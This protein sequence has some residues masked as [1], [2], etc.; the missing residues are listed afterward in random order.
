MLARRDTGISQK[1]FALVATLTALMLLAVIVLGMLSLSTIELRNANLANHRRQAQANARLALTQAIGQLQMAMGPD[2]R[3]SASSAL[4]TAEG[5]QHWT[6]VWDAQA[7]DGKPWVVRD[8]NTGGLKDRRLA[9]DY[10]PG[11]RV[12]RWLVSGSS[13]P[14]E[15]GPTRVKLV[16]AGSVADP[17]TMGV[18]VPAVEIATRGQRGKMAWWTGDLGQRANLATQATK[19]ARVA[20]QAAPEFIGN[21]PPMTANVRNRLVSE[22]SV[23]MLAGD[24]GWAKTH[25]HDF[26]VHSRG[27]LTNTRD[28]GLKQDLRAYFSSDGTL[29]AE[30]DSPGLTDTDRLAGPANE[31]EAEAAGLPW[32]R[33]PFRRAAPR[34]GVLRHW[35]G[36]AAPRAGGPLEA[37]PPETVAVAP[38]DVL[39]NF[40]PVRLD[41]AL[42]SSIQPILV[43]ASQWYSFSWFRKP[44]TDANRRHLRKHLYPKIVLWNPYS[45]AMTTR[46]MM[47]LLQV[48]GRHDFWIDGYFPGAKGKPG[49]PVHSPWLAF[50]GGR[51]RDFV[52]AD[53][54]LFSSSGYNDPHMGSYYYQ[55]APTRFAPGECLVFTP[56]KAGDYRN[57]VKEDGGDTNLA[58]NLLTAG[59]APHP[60]RCITISDLPGQPGF[61][62]VPTGIS[63]ESTAAHFALFGMQ[64]LRNPAEDLRVILKGMGSEKSVDVDGF[65]KLPQIAFISGSLQYGAGTEPVSPWPGSVKI[66]IEETTA[67]PPKLVP[68][69]RTRQGLRLRHGTASPSSR[70]EALF[71]N[72]NPRAAFSLRSPRE[73]F[74]TGE[75]RS[76]LEDNF[77]GFGIY[78]RFLPPMD[79]TATGDFLSEKT[80]ENATATIL[81]DLPDE[82][83]GVISIGSLQHAKLSDLVWLPSRVI[84]NSLADPRIGEENTIPGKLDHM[85]FTQTHLG[86]PSD[87]N[88]DAWASSA[89]AMLRN[90]PADD[91]ELSYDLAYETNHALW[92]RFFVSSEDPLFNPRLETHK[93]PAEA[94]S[95]FTD[96]HQAAFQ[97]TINGPLNVNSLSVDAWAAV[98]AGIR[99]PGAKTLHLTESEIRRL[100]SAVV[101]Q[102]KLRGPFLGMS[103]FVNRRLAPGVTGKFG[104]IEAA[105]Q[106]AGLNSQLT[107]RSPLHDDASTHSA[108][109]QIPAPL[110]IDP[111][112]KPESTAWGQADFLTQA[113]LLQVLGD[114]LTTRSDTFVIR[115]YGESLDSAGKPQARAWCEAVIQRIAAPVKAAATGVNPLR[116]PNGIDFGRQFR[117]INFR[118]LTPAEI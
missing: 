79:S 107:G 91:E 15:T 53:G 94:D 46:P 29:Q 76:G 13:G 30:G 39:A 62:F 51:S 106:A 11:E 95:T 34:F 69:G 19:D 18:T 25:F 71:A 75:G 52:S 38:P 14:D 45:V 78:E 96:F 8:P 12:M 102:V 80:G 67:S 37:I 87:G 112:L 77:W 21:G 103:D 115:A 116:E 113:D 86:S 36:L 54:S 44:G 111:T 66:P 7:P 114:S 108:P 47:V 110:A 28:G 74:H 83:T 104:A 85:G 73:R 9:S 55:I 41:G 22:A 3:V 97:L 31:L 61:A 72:W 48:N 57:G 10:Q 58:G 1:G 89:R 81:F 6:G 50:D 64:G 70:T 100:A 26:T 118:W 90:L 84:G 24:P 117:Q 33:N 63:M 5:Q 59:Q 56:E 88:P 98:L 43:E 35:A 4:V 65:D 27:L 60:E 16:G 109:P 49:F 40:Q 101:A 105:I 92:D 17:E 20:G 82:E 23:G 42:K 68:D 32:E 99:I 93:A 2:T